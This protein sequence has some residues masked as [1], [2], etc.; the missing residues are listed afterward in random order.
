VPLHRLI[1]LLGCVDDIVGASITEHAP[2]E[3]ADDAGDAVVIRR[4]G[5]ALRR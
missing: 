5:S 1:E 3:G 4:L 2:P